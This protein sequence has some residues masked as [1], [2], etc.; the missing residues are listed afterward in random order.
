MGPSAP[1]P[2]SDP[3]RKV[4]AATA[5][6]QAAQE[7]ELSLLQEF[8]LFLKENKAW[9]LVPILIALA[10]LGLLVGLSGSALAPFIY[11]LF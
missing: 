10:L 5:F 7:R 11:P 8:V 9:W 6:E 2:E 4:S 3:S 1:T